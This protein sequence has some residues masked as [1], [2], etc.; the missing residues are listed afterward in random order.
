M[1]LTALVSAYRDGLLTR[2]ELFSRVT[3]FLS[4]GGTS[5]SS[6]REELSFD[7]AVRSEFETWLKELVRYPKI[8]SGHKIV[9]VTPA[10][11]AEVVHSPTLVS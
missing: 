2:D 10:L 8:L 4:E 1:T 11:V 6:A 7:F 3:D 5:L 9:R